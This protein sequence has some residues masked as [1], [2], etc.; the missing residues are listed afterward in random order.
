M[1]GT[2]SGTVTLL[3]TDIEGSSALWES[4]RE[5]MRVALARHDEL[6]RSAI[7]SSGGHVFKTVGDAF[8][9]AFDVAEQALAAAVA[10]QRAIAAERW[11]EPLVLRVRMGMHSG[12]CSERDGDYFGPTVN[13]AARLQ[14]IAH[15]G[16]L[17]LSAASRELAADVLPDEVS[18]RDIGEH[19]LKDLERP[20]RVFQ[21]DIDGL[22]VDFPPL[23]S[24]SGGLLQHNLSVQASSFIGR[25]RE[26]AQLRSLLEASR[27]VTI[28]GSGG[29]G[30]TRLALQ[31]A[32]EL[33]DGSGD[34]VWFVDLAPL[35]DPD[36]LALTV[37]SVLGV[38]EEP[39]RPMLETLTTAVG[40]RDLLLVLDNCEH[41]VDAA[42]ALAG[43]LL[44][45][46]ARVELLVTGREPLSISGEQ[47]YR[48]PSLG[49]PDEQ[50]SDTDTIAGSE[51]V[52]LFMD[53]A[54]KQKPDLALDSSNAATIAR[55]CRRLDGIPLALELAAARLRS[56]SPSDLDVRLDDRFRVLKSTSRDALP[57]QQTLQALIDWSWNL[58]NEPERS[59]LA[60]LSVFAGSFDLDA[61]EAVAAPGEADESDVDDLLASLVDK[62]LVQTDEIEGAT[63]YRLLE[64]VRE[65]SSAKLVQEGAQEAVRRAHRDHYLALAEAASPHL[66]TRDAKT[67]LERL[68]REH[69]NL[70]GATV[71]SLSDTDPAP[72][73]RLA[74][75][76]R[77]FWSTRGYGHEGVDAAIALLDRSD[78]QAPT[79]LRAKALNAV[80]FLAAAF[81]SDYP[82]GQRR[83]EEALAIA[84][85][86]GD[87]EAMCAAVWNLTWVHIRREEYLAARALLEEALIHASTLRNPSHR[88]SLLGLRAIVGEEL[89]D[90][91]MARGDYEESLRLF[92]QVGDVERIAGV[93]GNLATLAI[94][95]RDLTTARAHLSEELTTSLALGEYMKVTVA[96]INLGLV[97]YL[98]GDPQRARSRFTEALPVARRLGNPEELAYALFGL[99][100]T[101][102]DNP[103]RAALLHGAVDAAFEQLGVPIERMEAELRDADHLRLRAAMGDQAF[104]QAY[105]EGRRM[106]L[107][108]AVALVEALLEDK[109]AEGLAAVGPKLS[110]RERELLD[111]VAEGLTDAQIAERLYISVKTVHS[112]LDRIRDKTGARRRP[113]LIRF[114]L[115][116]ASA[117]PTS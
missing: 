80:A 25:E 67:W 45:S 70:R 23:R 57:R 116:L 97:E 2:P 26:L 81:L 112:H 73:L 28:V 58:L 13:R 63:R 21:V 33:L 93:Q 64:T 78:T 68:D 89:G 111:L 31:L 22:A 110:R 108:E 19:R 107:D 27:L 88:A 59:V 74:V 86:L 95:Q 55:I 100:L 11:P 87:G 12:V 76:L 18:L 92:R 83:G 3:F 69:D 49:V 114:A 101:D 36:L 96:T 102:L 72:G 82:T 29:S 9:A 32:V 43:R 113:E 48:V 62:S 17:L 61:A 53:R 15:G 117:A 7:E 4:H 52:L 47:V 38:R 41:V 85:S 1:V 71:T 66:D 10:V 56:L 35:A 46:C 94:A 5:E 40:E 16:Q 20:E 77:R 105:Q 44:G 91:A 51:A 109:R 60:C 65:Y 50:A 30:K 39:D 79:I 104:E 24:L 99:A 54:A 90:E 42:A 75:A 37:A 14:A 84:R 8:C 103:A 34:G 106:Q 98:D 115:T 6:L